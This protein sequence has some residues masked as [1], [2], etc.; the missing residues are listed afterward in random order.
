MR[1]VP[2]LKKTN[3]S[4]YVGVSW[5]STANKWGARIRVEG[6]YKHLGLF[7]KPDE[8]H[9]AYLRAAMQYRPAELSDT[10]Q[11]QALLARVRA[12]YDEYGPRALTTRF[13]HR[14][15]RQLY[16][17]LRKLGLTQPVYLKELGL[18]ET[19]EHWRSQNKKYR[20]VIKP[21]WTWDE[22]IKRAR[23]IKDRF[24]S[25]PTLE[26]FRH[27]DN[28]LVSLANAVFKTGHTWQDLRDAVGDPSTGAFVQ[29]RNCRR[30]R[31]RPEA[32]L[33]DFLHARGVEHRPGER[34]AETYSEISGRRYGVYDMHFKAADGRW[35]DVEIWGRLEGLSRGRY[36][37]TRSHKESFNAGNERF[38]G[39]EMNDC[40]SDARLT[41]IL[42]P[43]I[44]EIAAFNFE[45]PYDPFIETS[46]FS[47]VD[48][49]LQ[50]CGK[51]AAQMPDGMF[52]S[53]NW[54][55]K[56]G[57]Y[58]DREGSPYNTLAHYVNQWV[59]GTRKVREFLG[60]GE[61]STT[62]WSA[63]LVIAKWRDFRETYGVSPSQALS[64]KRRLQFG[65]EAYNLANA[66]YAAATRHGVLDEARGGPH[67]HYRK[68]TPETVRVA[69]AA[70][71]NKYGAAPTHFMSKGKRKTIAREITDEATR[72]YQGASRLGLL[73]TL[74]A[75]STLGP[76]R[77][78]E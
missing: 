47:G 32:A 16:V 36:S 67:Q 26:W 51:L 74:R 77:S 37:Q 15:P 35:I 40:M 3:T 9:A 56:R 33:S 13:L 53:E 18:A 23:Q 59:G 19:F 10:Q 38:L 76:L 17:S 31:S 29:S 4:G 41:S 49:L 1:Q 20:G 7:D 50:T 78:D 21:K 72:I 24:G 30:W 68:W 64:P 71:V 69:W 5:H 28:G 70:F 14:Q 25:L 54:L 62:K 55:R 66:I 22:A 58:A 39:I 73:R 44:G 52:P 6:R 8:A 46:H 60:H 2:R 42:R 61:A 43:F 34:Y 11:R 57:K 63:E 12:L 65:A 27:P 48:E 75:M 45:R